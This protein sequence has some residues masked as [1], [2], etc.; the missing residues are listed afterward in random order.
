MKKLQRYDL[1]KCYYYDEYNKAI[2]YG[3]RNANLEGV[4]DYISQLNNARIQYEQEIGNIVDTERDNENKMYRLW[5]KWYKI[6]AVSLGIFLAAIPALIVCGMISERSYKFALHGDW[7]AILFSMALIIAFPVFLFAAAAQIIR[8]RWYY[9]YADNLKNRLYGISR[10]FE[11]KAGT[12]YRAIDNIYLNSL[13]PAHREMVL[14]RRE[15][16]EH[17]R[18]MEAVAAEQG[19]KENER[20]EETRKMRIAQ[21]KLLEIEKERER[22]RLR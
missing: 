9:D 12:C 13:D 7:L 3:K 4:N 10:N 18:R 16:E 2:D 6:R 5:G 8:R 22:R 17:N 11:D 19:R 20:L 1:E 15:Q 21:E 14:M